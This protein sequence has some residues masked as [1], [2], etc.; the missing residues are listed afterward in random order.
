[1]YPGLIEKLEK[2]NKEEREGRTFRDD[3]KEVEY[4]EAPMTEDKI[5]QRYDE[6]MKR[7]TTMENMALEIYTKVQ[8][9]SREE[10]LKEINS[11]CLYY[12]DEC[13]NEVKT[14][15][16]LRL[17]MAFHRFDEKYIEYFE[18]RKQLFLVVA[19]KVKE[20]STQYDNQIISL[21]KEIVATQR[22][23]L[24]LSAQIDRGDF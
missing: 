4:R 1:M 7:V 3:I 8:F 9:M 10:I 6:G 23:L 21:D 16:S 12:M 24:I 15:D 5:A 22:E 20:K 18:L 11:R 2:Q 13:I 14:I 19:K 17:P